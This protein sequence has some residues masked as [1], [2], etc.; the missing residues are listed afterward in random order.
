MGDPREVAV[1]GRLRPYA[2]EDGNRRIDGGRADPHGA[3]DVRGRHRAV[4]ATEVDRVA[5]DGK[6]RSDDTLGV[7]GQ[8]AG[9]I[10]LGVG[11]PGGDAGSRKEAEGDE[12]D[13]AAD[14]ERH[15]ASR[16]PAASGRRRWWRRRRNCRRRFCR[17]G[18][19][20]HRGH[21]FPGAL[22]LRPA[23]PGRQ[24]AMGLTPIK[25]SSFTPRGGRSCHERPRAHAVSDCCRA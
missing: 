16:V 25:G 10:A 2:D 23:S 5:R 12:A 24:D 9:R 18:G 21:S 17:C 15:H 1:D 6:G 11:R 13:H 20:R 3:E 14:D 8:V 4:P 22:T 19:D 7:D